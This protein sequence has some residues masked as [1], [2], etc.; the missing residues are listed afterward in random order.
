PPRNLNSGYGEGPRWGGRLNESPSGLRLRAGRGGRGGGEDAVPPLPV[1][2]PPRHRPPPDPRF[3]ARW[4]CLSAFLPRGLPHERG[5]PIGPAGFFCGHRG[6]PLLWVR[7][8][9]DPRW[10]ADRCSRPVR[11]WELCLRP[12]RRPYGRE[13]PFPERGPRLPPGDEG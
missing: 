5:V 13:S 6:P 7:R 4:G 10:K 12:G 11:R 9:Y 2:P 3:P 1:L 8:S